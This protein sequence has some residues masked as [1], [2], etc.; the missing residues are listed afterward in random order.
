MGQDALLGPLY[1]LLSVWESTQMVW[2]QGNS[3][4]TE[5]I[6]LTTRQPLCYWHMAVYVCSGALSGTG[7]SAEQNL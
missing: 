6:L 2:G 4:P 3:V 1:A 7:C 5:E